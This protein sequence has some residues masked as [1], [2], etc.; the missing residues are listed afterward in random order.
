MSVMTRYS[1]P[2]FEYAYVRALDPKQGTWAPKN[3]LMRFIVT[4]TYICLVTFLY[5]PVCSANSLSI[6]RHGE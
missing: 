6:G 4:T 2:T 1:R 3:I 5:A